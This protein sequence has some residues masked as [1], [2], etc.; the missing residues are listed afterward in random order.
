MPFKAEAALQCVTYAREV[1]GL[2]LKG[3]A[4]K[5]W[6]AASGLYKRG[7]APK[8]GAVLV[9]KRQGSMVHGH[10]AVVRQT[11]SP[12]VLLVDHANWA[13]R[14]SADR[15]KVAESVP[16][17]DVSPN[18]DWTQVRVWYEPS[19]QYGD[20]V[21]K[22]VGFVY[23]PGKMAPV[24]HASFRT[25]EPVAKAAEAPVTPK[26]EPVALST[27]APVAPSAPVEAK[28]PVAAVVAPAPTPAPVAPAVPVAAPT[29]AKDVVPGKFD[30]RSWAEQA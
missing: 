13:P 19:Q 5:W 2:N 9:F 12:R 11:T 29:P 6:E 28:A 14:R 18:N 22:T 24:E 1:T 3:D 21:Y 27:P 10:V 26:A 25:S 7:N 15:G 4:W 23:N 20:R 30:A 8:E 17:M 16:V